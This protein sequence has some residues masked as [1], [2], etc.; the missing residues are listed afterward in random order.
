MNGRSKVTNLDEESDFTGGR[1]NRLNRGI[2]NEFVRMNRVLDSS[3]LR[4]RGN[5]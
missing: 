2:E 3:R 4:G 1:M 5:V